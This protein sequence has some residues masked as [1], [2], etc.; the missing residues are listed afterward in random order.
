V[1]LVLDQQVCGGKRNLESLVDSLSTLV[2]HGKTSL[3]G[4]TVTLA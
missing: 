1:A 2:A 3:N 4:L